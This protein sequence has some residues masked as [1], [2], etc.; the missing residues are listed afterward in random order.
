MS[1]TGSDDTPPL[2]SAVLICW[3]VASRVFPLL[4]VAGEVHPRSA[5]VII[6][7]CAFDKLNKSKKVEINKTSNDNRA[8]LLQ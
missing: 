8:L 1:V 3:L 2:L 6:T 7:S 4:L 5:N